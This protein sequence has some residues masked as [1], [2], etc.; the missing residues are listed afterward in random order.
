MK[1]TL[2]KFENIQDPFNLNN[3]LTGYITIDQ[4]DHY[5]QLLLTHINGMKC[6]EQVIYSTPK[7]HYPFSKIGNFYFKFLDRSAPVYDK[8]DGTNILG[9]RYIYRRKTYLSYKTRIN[10]ILLNGRYGNFYS[11]WCEMLNRYP[12]IVKAIKEYDINFSYELYGILNKHLILY[13]IRLDTK[14]LFGLDKFTGAIILPDEFKNL[15]PVINKDCEIQ[16]SYFFPD[17]YKKIRGEIEAMNDYSNL[18]LEE[19]KGSEG[20]VIYIKENEQWKQWKCK[21]ETIFQIHT[22][23]G[24]GKNDIVTTCYNALENVELDDLEYEFVAELLKEEF[25]ER[26]IMA[27]EVRIKNI[28]EEV[29]LEVKRRYLVIETYEKFG[30]KLGE[31]KREVMHKMNEVFH[32][33]EMRYVYSII[34]AFE[35]KK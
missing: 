17:F 1:E 12:N 16:P 32:R 19:I 4:G 2:R 21:P 9:F 31:R 34:Q 3:Y 14:L 20:R 27:N 18:E 7:M 25:S 28:I 33:R 10:P 11:M 29:K 8:L 6:K 24:L 5:G 22:K 15:L 23:P 26:E 35:G 30:M 13:P